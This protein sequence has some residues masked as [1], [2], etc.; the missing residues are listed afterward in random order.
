MRWLNK[1]LGNNIPAHY[2]D[3]ASQCNAKA[4]L[5]QPLAEARFVVFDTETT[6][7]NPKTDRILSIGA[8]AVQGFSVLVEDSFE[9][10]VKQEFT[11][12]HSIA[13]HEITPGSAAMAAPEQ[14]VL[15]EFIA[16]IGPSVLIGH[17]VDFD[18]AMVNN[19]TKRSLDLPL[20]NRKYDTMK[21]L[22]RT[23]NHFAQ[24]GLHRADDLELGA[25]CQRYNIPQTG[26][27]TAIG[28]ALA[29]ALL[30]AKHLKK[31]E[32]RGV[33]TVGQLLSR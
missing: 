14:L 28:D 32:K 29:T 33:K 18:F 21:L 11:K 8:V 30:F 23:D 19:A 4:V 13:I 17:Y 26:R 31:L 22:Q 1:I 2:R 16:Y 20:Q 25:L 24:P 27:H 9:A 7:L 5:S 15:E 6:G 12:N 3:Y 10:Y